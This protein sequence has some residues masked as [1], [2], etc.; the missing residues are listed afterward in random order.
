MKTTTGRS[1]ST[2]SLKPSPGPGAGDGEL[3]A[4]EL[5]GVPVWPGAE[6]A[7]RA[8]M[9]HEW[10]QL[11]D[12]ERAVLVAAARKADPVAIEAALNVVPDG[13]IDRDV[14]RQFLSSVR[15]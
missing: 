14:L 9:A 15:N 11:S 13:H 6:P 4:D 5:L 1:P 3:H 2:L 12:D 10:E 8:R 7:D